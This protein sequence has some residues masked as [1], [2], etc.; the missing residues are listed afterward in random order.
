MI[1]QENKLD[2]VIQFA[3]IEYPAEP[4]FRNNLYAVYSVGR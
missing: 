3:D 4:V 1:A 2:Y